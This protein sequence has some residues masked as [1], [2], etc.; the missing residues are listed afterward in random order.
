[1]LK[2]FKLR[3]N[4]PLNAET[5]IWSAPVGAAAPSVA[6]QDLRRPTPPPSDTSPHRPQYTAWSQ[7]QS[8]MLSGQPVM[9]TPLQ[10]AMVDNPSLVATE[11][12]NGVCVL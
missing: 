5:T 12:D 9:H 2:D 10:S 6:E 11:A 1:M 7:H 8:S 3:C 4:R